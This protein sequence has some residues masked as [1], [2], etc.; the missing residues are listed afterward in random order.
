MKKKITITALLVL[1]LLFGALYHTDILPVRDCN[2]V[3][4]ILA[5]AVIQLRKP[6]LGIYYS[7]IALPFA[8]FRN[9]YVLTL[10]TFAAFLLKEKRLKIS[11]IDYGVLLFLFIVL[12]A[13]IIAF[14]LISSFKS[15][16]YYVSAVMIMFIIAKSFDKTKL[17]IL[18]LCFLLSATVVSLI[19]I[20]QYFTL[21]MSPQLWLWADRS[22]NAHLRVRVYST[23]DNPNIL[24]E[25]LVI[26]CSIGTGLFLQ[27]GTAWKKRIVAVATLIN[28]MCLLATFSRGGW[29]GLALAC[30]IILYYEER[31]LIPV[32][33]TLGAMLLVFLPVE[34]MERIKS[35]ANISDTA[36]A[37]RFIIWS[38]SLRM[39]KDSWLIGNGYGTFNQIYPGYSATT[40]NFVHAHNVFLNIAV[41]TG[42][43]GLLMFLFNVAVTCKAGLVTARNAI[44]Q[45]YRRL[46]YTSTAAL[47]GLLSHG[48]VD[49]VLYDARIIFMFWMLIGIIF[50]A[51]NED[52]SGDSLGNDS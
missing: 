19:G 8:N 51:G 1:S 23:L 31:K 16:Y 39:F 50:A 36:N 37:Y 38:A 48:L 34:V 42:I 25:Y 30:F 13:S 7:M 11:G 3:F 4:L 20:Y 29:L 35:I 6:E 32:I 33:L 44:D 12:I 40:V 5:V 18:L 46:S 47:S 49:H 15:F 21:E 2:V 28:V 22:T 24:A 10:F 9:V 52:Y 43:W 17:N 26:A 41:E 45:Y 27:C 14:P